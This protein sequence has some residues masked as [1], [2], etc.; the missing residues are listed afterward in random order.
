MLLTTIS[1][2]TILHKPHTS[3]QYKTHT[4][5]PLLQ[6]IQN[7]TVQFVTFRAA[8]WLRRSVAGLS[9]Q[10]PRFIPVHYSIEWP[11]DRF[12]SEYSRCPLSASFPPMLHTHSPTQLVTAR[13]AADNFSILAFSLHLISFRYRLLFVL[14][15][16]RFHISSCRSFSLSEAVHIFQSRQQR[17]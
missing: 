9:L 15:R 6:N 10:R 1:P 11:W 17:L 7:H 5:T 14:E 8:P 12:F 4:Y 2:P 16:C 13:L 3:I